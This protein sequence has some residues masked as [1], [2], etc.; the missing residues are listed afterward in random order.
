MAMVHP[1][2]FWGHWAGMARYCINGHGPPSAVLGVTGPGWL[3][4][5]LMAMVHPVL[6]C[7]H[8]PGW[9]GI[10]LMAMVHPVLF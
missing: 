6:F 10:V 8:W 7:G 2:L 3:G 5:V 4:V 9:L 1:V